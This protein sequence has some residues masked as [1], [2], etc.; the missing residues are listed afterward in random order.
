M[1]EKGT[2][3]GTYV[4]EDG[5]KEGQRL[6]IGVIC[7]PGDKLTVKGAPNFPGISNFDC[8]SGSLDL[9]QRDAAVVTEPEVEITVETTNGGSFWVQARVYG[10]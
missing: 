3:T 5:L 1:S 6:T 7:S 4:I 9:N 2:G 10:E 8:A